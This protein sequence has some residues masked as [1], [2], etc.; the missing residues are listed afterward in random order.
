MNTIFNNVYKYK[1][2]L[3]IFI[4]SLSSLTHGLNIWQYTIYNF[5]PLYMKENSQN[6]ILDPIIMMN[7]NGAFVL[8]IFN[9]LFRP[10][11]QVPILYIISSVAIKSLIIYMFYL[12]IDKLICNKQLALII[13]LFFITSIGYATHGV[14]INGFWGAPIFFRA[15]VSGLMTLFG[16]YLLLNNRYYLSI[17]PF[18]LAIHLHILYGVTSFAFIFASFIFYSIV[19]SKIYIKELLIVSVVTGLSA[20]F[21]ILN[22]DSSTFNTVGSNIEQWYK[23]VFATD[24]DDMSMLYYLGTEGYFTAPFLFLTVYFYFTNKDKQMIDYLFMGSFIFLFIIMLVEVLH[25]NSIFFGGPSEKFIGVQFRR[26]MWILLLFSTIINFLNIQKLIIDNEDN[27][28]VYLLIGCGFIYLFPNIIALY[29]VLL[30]LLIYFK[31]MKTIYLLLASV[32]F[33]Y[34]GHVLDFYHLNKAYKTFAFILVSTSFISGLFYYKLIERKDVL[35]S[36]IIFFV[37]STALIGVIKGNFINDLNVIA[38]NSLFKSP[39]LLKLEEDIY[40]KQ[41]KVV[42][43]RIINYIRNN[44]PKKEF[45]LESMENVTYGDKI[46]YGCPIYVSRTIIAMPMFSKLYYEFLLYKLKPFNI[47]ENMLFNSKGTTLKSIDS[48]TGLLSKKE[49]VT[50]NNQQKIRFLISKNKFSF[51]KPLISE[52]NYFL[53]DLESIK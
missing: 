53:Y 5:D 52:N 9:D 23:Y 10:L 21:I 40:K 17:I 36:I 8:N 20:L 6:Y 14:V 44:N 12:I 43:N 19:S 1:I 18:S 4:V 26:G 49:M 13:S 35:L 27:K 7:N 42:N 15:S 3:I 32:S 37:I 45:V 50:L 34:L 22:I 25:Y 30:I 16:I 46:M 29:A 48:N 28:L 33:L 51:M 11:L 24:P 2:I 38:N 39:N 41:G 47:D 31:Q